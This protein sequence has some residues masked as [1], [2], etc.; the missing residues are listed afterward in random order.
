MRPFI[1]KSPSI[2]VVVPL[3]PIFTGPPPRETV[4]VV[5]VN[6]LT[7]DA[8]LV[9]I[10]SPPPISKSES[11]VVFVD[12]ADKYVDI[13]VKS[14]PVVAPLAAVVANT[15]ESALSSHPIKTL[16]LLPLS[17][18][19]PKSK[20]FALAEF[21]PLFN[22]MRV[23]VR[24]ELVLSTVVVDPCTV[25]SALILTFPEELISNGAITPAD[26]NSVPLN[27]LKVPLSLSSYPITYLV[28]FNLLLNFIAASSPALDLTT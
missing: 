23:S 19:I 21:A 11:N 22:S 16:L 26:G 12:V 25:K 1:D 6:I 5:V 24:T 15:K 4:P 3:A 9:A 28:S 7:A 20:R 13:R 27:I 14:S 18:I 2:V 17:I 8:M 10:I